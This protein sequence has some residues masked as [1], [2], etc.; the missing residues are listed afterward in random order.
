[1]TTLADILG[2]ERSRSCC[3]VCHEPLGL[4]FLEPLA[5]Q[6]ERQESRLPSLPERLWVDIGGEGGA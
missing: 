2:E 4:A 1:M 3:P 6:I 5:L